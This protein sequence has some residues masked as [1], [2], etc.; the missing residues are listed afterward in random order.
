MSE[1]TVIL[2]ESLLA[3]ISD[4][5]VNYGSNG[6]LVVLLLVVFIAWNFAPEFKR[7][8]RFLLSF[9]SNNGLIRRRKTNVKSKETD[10]DL[11]QLKEK[12]DLLALVAK[13]TDNAVVITDAH[14]RIEWVNDG[15]ERITGYTSEEVIGKSP[16][17]LLQGEETDPA[18]IQ[19]MRSCIKRRR[20]FDCELVNY[21]K[22]GKKYW[23]AIEVRP[24][25]DESGNVV[26]FIAIESDITDRKEAEAEKEL[27]SQQFQVAARQAGMSEVAT[28][29]LHN[30]G[31]KLN[32]VCVSVDALQNFAK[33]YAKST[34][35]I[36]KA[37]EL[38]QAHQD[39]LPDFFQNDERGRQLPT[40]FSA[41]TQSFTD[42]GVEFSN[43]LELLSRN[44]EH[45]K[46]IVAAQNS[47]SQLAGHVQLTEVGKLI[48]DCVQNCQN[49][50]DSSTTT[51]SVSIEPT[52]IEVTLDSYKVIQILN[53]LL[54]NAFEAVE[55]SQ[56]G[57]PHVRI[58]AVCRAN[59]LGISVIDNGIGVAP[60]D[61]DRIFQFGTTTK[62]DGN[63]FGL[64]HSANLAT[65]MGG[66]LSVSSDGIG[67]GCKF[68]LILPNNS[69]NDNNANKFGSNTI[70]HG[71]HPKMATPLA[72]QSHDV[73]MESIV[74]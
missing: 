17:G 70:T 72:N 2:N 8:F 35:R 43:E 27:L 3:E 42:L 55:E 37:V 30:V 34:N 14:G 29:V 7:I 64:H 50:T 65:E 26:K 39:S 57:N 49:L 54:K 52:K 71:Q 24:I 10:S 28:G 61:I 47:I 68:E 4:F 9:R 63:G 51:L 1:Q 15:F 66:S 31:N 25:H 40:Y 6:P 69:C 22:A 46:E 36:E 38:I 73:A 18:T 5:F 56:V 23:L 21:S 44:T 58:V 19:H 33:S 67:K 16:G 45:I 13:Y 74:H 12:N 41:V 53:N 48:H 32:S 11:I 59:R 20:G 62:A 60:E